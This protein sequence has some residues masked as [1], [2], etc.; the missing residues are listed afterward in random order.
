[1]SRADDPVPP[2]P[3]VSTS[4]AEEAV[5]WDDPQE[6]ARFTQRVPGE[7]GG[8]PTARSVLVIEGM[9]CAAC[10]V[11]I[12]EALMRLPG[13]LEADVNPA[14]RRARVLW[15]PGR[16]RASRIAEAVADAGYRAYPALSV[17]AEADRRRE[18]RLALWRLFVAGLCMMQV[19]M[20]AVPTY[21]VASTGSEDMSRD[22]WQLLQWASW[23]LSI[24]V[25]LFSA[26]P[27][28]QGA[29]RDLRARRI[30]MDVPVALG[31]VVTFIASTGATFDPGGLFG[32]EVYF[33]SLTMFVFFLLGGRY[34]ALRSHGATA[35]ALESLMQRLPETVE[36][37]APDGH[38]ETLP[39]SRL[40]A[41]DRVRV[42]AGQAFP[43]DG[44]IEAGTVWVDEALL[45]GEST[46]LERGPGQPVVAGSFNLSAPVW[47]RVE[48]AGPDTR[49]A[50]IVELMQRAATDRP[51]FVQAVDRIAAPFLWAVLAA[52][53]LCA[54]AW[55]FIDP[56]RSVWV[57][58]AVLIVTCPC[59]L[60]LA[61]PSAL[62]SAA[63]ALA[64]R[65]VLVQRL[66]ALEALAQAR[67]F[68]FDKTGTLTEDRL[69]L[70][71]CDV[72]A[73]SGSREDALARAASL[74]QAS[75]HPVSRALVEAAAAARAP[76]LVEVREHPGR[77][78][79]GQDAQARL[80]RL[81]TRSHALGTTEPEALQPAD[82]A[83]GP[84]AW[85]S[86]D[87]ELVARFDFSERLRPDAR[88][89]IAALRAE[90][91]ETVLLSGD[92]PEAVQALARSL[93]M[94]RWQ[95]G[96]R[97]E[98]K[99]STVREAQARGLKL[100]MVGDGV[101]DGPVLAQADVSLAMGQGAALA[102]AQADFTLMSGRLGDVVAAWSLARR[103]VR[104]VRQNLAWAAAYN[105]TG[106]PLAAIGWMPPW[107][108]G[109]GMA[110]SS[111]L[112][113]VNAWRLTCPAEAPGHSAPLPLAS[114][115]AAGS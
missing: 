33:D 85:L 94:D 18:E 103:T 52:A 12:E 21:G 36:R 60:S 84:Q 81:G 35:G 79:E 4:L 88:A 73:P 78:L 49:Y 24:P 107:L 76:E 113:I 39:V 67:V 101:N 61:T 64:R 51:P 15:D 19:M 86:V 14:S 20:Y 93:G 99:L 43:A 1:M 28:L 50:Q 104:I 30:G 70:S 11:N 83:G 68:V 13:V 111:L 22:I 82:T 54:L 31:I 71:H 3:A 5:A 40:Q 48:R 75:L 45:T 44:R 2:P 8:S 27:F 46:P 87:G 109:L 66:Q 53:G 74:A 112:V 115:A 55:A 98:D 72:W 89:A 95:A 77:G 65:G 114:V 102:R 90:G 9:Y 91:L 26:G 69:E 108:A 56:S 106:I 97:P 37:E 110:A 59:A 10:S 17:Q 29:W 42:R 41:G 96:A 62:L 32:E 16:V 63:G 47:V 105:A 25:L 92:C 23:L 57:A 38:L 34:L 58:V 100:A 7:A 6:Q 80:W